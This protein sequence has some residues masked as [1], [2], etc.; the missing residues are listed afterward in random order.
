MIKVNSQKAIPA[1]TKKSRKPRNISI[2]FE[3]DLH[4]NKR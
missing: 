3:L 1:I 4:K 2:I